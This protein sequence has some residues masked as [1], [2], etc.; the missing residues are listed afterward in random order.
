METIPKLAFRFTPSN[1]INGFELVSFKQLAER[2]PDFTDHDP[3]QHHRLNFYAILL[4][5]GTERV[6]HIVDF[7]TCTLQQGDCLIIAKDQVHAFNP[8]ANYE[9]YL[10]LFTEAFFEKYIAQ[11][12]G[13]E[14]RRGMHYFLGL[15]KYHAPELAKHFI[16]Q[17]LE[18]HEREREET[19][20][21]IVAALLTIFLLSIDKNQESRFG[22][23]IRV[24]DLEYFNAF[25][26]LLV[27]D[28]R[29]TR[30]AK[31]YAEALHISYKR[32]N[33]ICKAVV[34]QTAKSYID[35]YIILEAKRYLVA[36]SHS[37]KEISYDLGFD[38]PTNFLKYFKKHT[39]L[40]PSEFRALN[41]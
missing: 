31:D 2:K 28:Y 23:G 3:H 19:R 4:M 22:E 41:R 11:A 37:A 39:Q 35:N 29:Y 26:L 34:G 38:E 5:T 9:G 16:E 25:R 12:T 40:T 21:S 30:D 24:K 27:E 32:L 33:S 10:I 14:I 36:S 20:S 13:E 15:N 1:T 6:E 7:E 8:L 17:L 18:V